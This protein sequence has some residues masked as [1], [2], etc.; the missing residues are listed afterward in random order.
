[1]LASG[2]CQL[3]TDL[4]DFPTIAHR[5]C[6]SFY[7]HVQAHNPECSLSFYPLSKLWDKVNGFLSTLRDKVNGFNSYHPCLFLPASTVLV[8]CCFSFLSVEGFSPAS[9]LDT[10]SSLSIVPVPVWTHRRNEIPQHCLLLSCICPCPAEK[11]KQ[12]LNFFLCRMLLGPFA[13]MPGVCAARHLPTHTSR[14][15]AISQHCLSAAAW[16]IP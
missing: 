15:P 1:M 6:S 8:L 14:A 9:L 12:D 5:L 3:S 4:T 11:S 7:R 16:G 2:P 13:C 10:S